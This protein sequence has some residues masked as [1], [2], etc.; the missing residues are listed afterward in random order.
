MKIAVVDDDSRMAERLRACFDE[1][2]GDFE[3]TYFQNGETFLSEWAP[4]AFDLVILDIFMGGM[5]GVEVARELRKRDRTV[6]LAFSTTSNEFASES[7]EVNACYYLRKP[8]GK[9]QVRAL[10]DRLDMDKLEQLRTV[11]LPGGTN[12]V[13]RSI[14]YADYSAHC[15]ILHTTAG[16]V[17]LRSSFSE[18]ESLLC[19][20]DCFFSPTKGVVINFYEVVSQVNDTF[21]M[22]DGFVVPI[23][24]R[25]AREVLDAYSTFLFEQLRRGGAQ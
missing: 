15:T 20:Y 1:F 12:I 23:S 16:N 17:T 22:S 24:R 9:E 5:S 4:G 11:R 10:L 19:A 6:K 3:L 18:I 25:R 21:R 7:Y 2:L 13:L 8:Y 14:I